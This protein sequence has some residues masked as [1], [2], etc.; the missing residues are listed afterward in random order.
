[1]DVHVYTRNSIKRVR[2]VCHSSSKHQSYPKFRYLHVFQVFQVADFVIH[3][4]MR[5]RFVFTSLSQA[6]LLGSSVAK[7]RQCTEQWPLLDSI[8][9]G[10]TEGFSNR[11]SNLVISLH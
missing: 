5:R 8:I 6:V 2:D 4:F 3:T 11:R 7:V 9:V 1:M 10:Q